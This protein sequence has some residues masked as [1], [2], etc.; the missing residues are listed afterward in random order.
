MSS[1]DKKAHRPRNIS[2]AHLRFEDRGG[3]TVVV[4]D[5]SGR[6]GLLKLYGRFTLGN[7]ARAYSRL[8]GI[9]GVPAWCDRTGPDTL[10]MEYLPG[11]PLSRIKPGAVPL[12]VFDRLDRIVAEMHRRGVANSDIHRANVLVN[13]TGEVFL[14]DFAHAIVARDPARPGVLARLCMDLD[15]HACVRMR[16]RYGGLAAPRPE[17]VFGLLYIAGS[18]WKKMLRLAKKA[19]RTVVG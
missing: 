7:E 12:E 6:K 8:A 13:G 1:E 19:V 3:R 2:K 10:E 14:V 15:R 4:K 16:A 18:A 5:Y 17:G 9:S 11:T